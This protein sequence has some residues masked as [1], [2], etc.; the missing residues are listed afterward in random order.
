MDSRDDTKV[1]TTPSSNS[2][3]LLFAAFTCRQI[4]ADFANARSTPVL[5]SESA[6]LTEY[7]HSNIEAK[8]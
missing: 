4:E 8:P 3:V 7:N 6:A 2:F 5:A 1:S